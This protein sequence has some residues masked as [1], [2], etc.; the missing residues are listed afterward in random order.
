MYGVDFQTQED[1]TVLGT[2]SLV[3]GDAPEEEEQQPK[4]DE[5]PQEQREVAM[6]TL[7]GHR[8]DVPAQIF[9]E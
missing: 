2:V 3:I 6:K 7:K 4:E 1:Q 8:K 9:R 5:Q